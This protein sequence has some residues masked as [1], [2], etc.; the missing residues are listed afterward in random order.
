MSSPTSTLQLDDEPPPTQPPEPP[1]EGT[2]TLKVKGVIGGVLGGLGLVTLAVL[3]ISLTRKNKSKGKRLRT[4]ER[5]LTQDTESNQGT[6]SQTYPPVA[7]RLQLPIP[8]SR[9]KDQH[10]VVIG[11]P[12]FPRPLLGDIQTSFALQGDSEKEG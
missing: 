3:I 11:P 12:Q 7:E 5:P 4:I 6:R 9:S 10:P 8:R 1:H 2:K